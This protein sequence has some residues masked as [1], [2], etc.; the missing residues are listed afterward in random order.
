MRIIGIANVRYSLLA[1]ALLGGIL[2]ASSAAAGGHKCAHGMPEAFKE[3]IEASLTEKF[4]L[5]FFMH[6]QT[7]PAIVTKVIDEH[8]IEGRN[9]EYGRIIIRLGQVNAIARN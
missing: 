5:T 8:T 3:L 9:Q 7:L 2:I 6:G 1:S 4:G